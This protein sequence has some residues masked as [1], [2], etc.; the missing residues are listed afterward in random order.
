[1]WNHV[2]DY[3]KE[4]GENTSRFYSDME[5]IVMD[6]DFELDYDEVRGIVAKTRN[7]RKI[8]AN[9]RR[10]AAKIKAKLIQDNRNSAERLRIAT[11]YRSLPIPSVAFNVESLNP[12]GEI[13]NTQRG[14]H[15]V[16]RNKRQ[17]LGMIVRKVQE[18]NEKYAFGFEYLQPPGKIGVIPNLYFGQHNVSDKHIF[19]VTVAGPNILKRDIWQNIQVNDE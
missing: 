11:G 15:T 3:L 2:E 12:G 14:N 18:W 8:P 5:D 16:P 1:M 7:R 19:V 9:L 4:V 17:A 10:K 6:G 13:V